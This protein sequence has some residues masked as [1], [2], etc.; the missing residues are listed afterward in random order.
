MT[1]NTASLDGTQTDQERHGTWEEITRKSSKKRYEGNIYLKNKG[2]LNSN[3]RLVVT[4][5][6]YAALGTDNLT[7]CNEDEMHTIYSKRIPSRKET[8]DEETQHRIIDCPA[9]DATQTNFAMRNKAKHNLYNQYLVHQKLNPENEE[10]HYIPTIIN[11][12]ILE[13]EESTI[14]PQMTK[15]QRKMN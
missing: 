11:S 8:Q 7:P 4:S 10:T 15:Q 3:D 13:K 1:T 2:S 5:N 6:Q 12:Q 9:V 14:N